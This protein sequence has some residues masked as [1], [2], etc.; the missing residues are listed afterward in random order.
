MR[1]RVLGETTHVEASAV[2][3]LVLRLLGMVEAD[4]VSAI[5]QARSTLVAV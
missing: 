4:I 5:A 1:S 3:H 2:A